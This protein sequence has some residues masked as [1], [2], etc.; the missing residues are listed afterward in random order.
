[1][2]NTEINGYLCG[3]KILSFMEPKYLYLVSKACHWPYSELIYILAHFFIKVSL[4]PEWFL[5][6]GF[7]NQKCLYTFLV[8]P[9][10]GICPAH[11]VLYL[12]TV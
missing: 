5:P 3:Q 6:M 12:I 7:S 2:V 10:C 4:S 11:L 9:M 8:S 1:M